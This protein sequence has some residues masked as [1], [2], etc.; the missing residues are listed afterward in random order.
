MCVSGLAVIITASEVLKGEKG[1]LSF[2]SNYTSKW[3]KQCALKLWEVK[4]PI[5]CWSCS[6]LL[7]FP[8][9]LARDRAL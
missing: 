7:N 5:R 2:P 1:N 9:C 6:A 8:W 3:L 4:A